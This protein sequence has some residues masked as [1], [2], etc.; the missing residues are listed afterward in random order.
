MREGGGWNHY[1]I[2]QFEI[3]F[4]GYILNISEAN[5][6]NQGV[7]LL[8]VESTS[9]SDF[10]EW[11]NSAQGHFSFVISK[12]KKTLCCVDKVRTIPMFY[13]VND[14][15]III[16][17]CA[18]DIDK[19]IGAEKDIYNSQ[20]ALEISMS[21]YTIGKKTLHLQ[22]SQLC[23]GE[24]LIVRKNKVKV[25]EYYRYSPWNVKKKSKAQLKKELTDVSR[26][27]LEDMV[28]NADGRQ[29]VIPLSAGNDS[30]FIASGLKELGVKNVFCF[31]YGLENNFEVKTAGQ[32]AKHLGYSWTHIP[33]SVE[34][35][36]K[37]FSESSFDDFWRYTD[38]FSN[39]PVLIDY[40]AVKILKESG[41]ISKEAIFVNGNSGDFIT[42]GHVNPDIQSN[43]NIGID[44]LINL[45]TEKHYS[46][47][48]CLKS[49]DNIE[50]IQVELEREITN[51][52]NNY[53]LSKTSFAEIGENIEWKG[54]QSKIVT[55]TQRSYEF[56]GYEWRLPLWDPIYMDFWE[57]VERKYK[58]NQSL[59]IET[60]LENN[61]GGV[62]GN[63]TV[64]NFSIASSRLRSFR[65]FTK[66]FFV[67]FEKRVWHQFDK[68]FFA[69]F[70]DDTAATAIVPYRETF[71][72]RCGAR[73]RNS[74][75]TK[76]YLNQHKMRPDT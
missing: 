10:C 53:G 29:F 5:F 41:K 72:D 25:K 68:K 51:L 13:A 20:A 16:G 8:D 31:S 26:Q 27:V 30:R 52:I 37:I 65:E 62:W 49:T 55:A 28:E 36:K 64:N 4:N 32:V 56:F 76:K 58:I 45:I 43:Y 75:I 59:Y 24:L 48:N 66:L 46:L 39:S 71:F 11:A 15:E 9:D 1:K 44:G 69:Y 42:G 40:S 6:L 22:I 19:A 7:N 54:R 21:G 50:K 34:I 17:N 67:F 12:G 18:D 61:W 57:G 47:W 14:K 2:N 23:A 70:Y 38:T 33:L 63:I 74:W 60:L 35:Q 3:W 73:N